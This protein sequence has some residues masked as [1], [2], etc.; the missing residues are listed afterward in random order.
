MTKK[1]KDKNK[2]KLAK[3]TGRDSPKTS[4]IRASCR[5]KRP[6]VSENLAVSSTIYNLSFDLCH[7]NLIKLID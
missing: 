2:A 3:V 1:Q 5:P 4:Q 6:L 7:L